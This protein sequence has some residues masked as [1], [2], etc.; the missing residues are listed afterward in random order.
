M[1]RKFKKIYVSNMCRKFKIFF[2]WSEKS[3]KMPQTGGI[4]GVY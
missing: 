4:L 2:I 1:C 3:K